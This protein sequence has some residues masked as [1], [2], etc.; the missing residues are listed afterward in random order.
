[1][2]AVAS[3][4]GMV[5]AEINRGRNAAQAALYASIRSGHVSLPGQAVRDL[6]SAEIYK[7]WS[8]FVIT[9]QVEDGERLLARVRQEE[10]RLALSRRRKKWAKYFTVTISVL[11]LLLF[12]AANLFAIRFSNSEFA[13]KCRHIHFC[14]ITGPVLQGPGGDSPADK[15]SSASGHQG[16]FPPGDSNSGS[17]GGQSGHQGSVGDMPVTKV[18]TSNSPEPKP[19]AI[20]PPASA[21]CGISAGEV[22]CVVGKVD[23]LGQCALAPVADLVNANA[24]KVNVP[25]LGSIGQCVAGKSPL[26]PVSAADGADSVG[27]SA[28]AGTEP[29]GESPAISPLS[30][31]LPGIQIPT[32]APLSGHHRARCPLFL[33]YPR[34]APCLCRRPRFVGAFRLA[35]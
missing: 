10:A 30:S 24:L 7:L 9:K 27:Q 32:V 3:A 20:L 33:A 14:I 25:D 15:A 22:P 13:A 29:D 35:G 6:A 12:C 5:F 2:A 19:T 4:F 31:G 21:D 28:A 26:S 23:Q 11:I 1:V 17:L 16:P 34:A 8:A 18:S